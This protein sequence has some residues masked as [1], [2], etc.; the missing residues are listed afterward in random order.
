MCRTICEGLTEV[1]VVM[2]KSGKDLGSGLGVSHQREGD[3]KVN[4]I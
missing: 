1:L 4:D 2:A 3:R